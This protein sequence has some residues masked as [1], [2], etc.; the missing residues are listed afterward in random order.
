MYKSVQRVRT[1]HS[2]QKG[3]NLC[4]V[5]KIVKF[6][7]LY[8]TRFPNLALDNF[9]GSFI[10]LLFNDW[11]SP[12]QGST[13]LPTT[14]YYTFVVTFGFFW[15]SK[16]KCLTLI[17]PHKN[18]CDHAPPPLLGH[19]RLSLVPAGSRNK[20]HFEVVY[21]HR[22]LWRGPLPEFCNI[23]DIFSFNHT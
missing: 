7:E 14:N 21:T 18:H 16:S 15:D 22:S 23:Q 5:S 8:A 9:F 12:V 4:N 1:V 13:L 3:P 11:S 6:L 20:A 17:S 10:S 2:V 19:L